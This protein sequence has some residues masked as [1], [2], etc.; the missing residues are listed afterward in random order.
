MSMSRYV[1]DLEDKFLDL[2]ADAVRAIRKY[3]RSIRSC[4]GKF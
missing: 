3:W 4:I 1:L 2:V